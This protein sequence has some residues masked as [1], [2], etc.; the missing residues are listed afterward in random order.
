[1]RQALELAAQ[2]L[3]LTSP[4]PA[5]G[6]LVV[7][8]GRILGRGWHQRA[9]QPHAEIEAFQAARTARRRL[10]D[11]TLYVTLEPC[12]TQGRTPPCTEA[13]LKAG[14]TRV[15]VGAV[16]PNP[17]HA[18]HGLEVL[19][20][21]GVEVVTGV[22]E[23]ECT[24]LNRAFN[25]WIMHGTPWTLLK[26]AMTLDGKIATA[27]GRS[28][29]I[30]GPPARD[31]VMAL[32]RT[33]DAILVGIH[34]VLADDPALTVRWSVPQ[35]ESPDPPIR[36]PRRI[37]L[38]SQARTPLRA[39]VLRDEHAARTIV[40]VT[41]AAPPDRVKALGKMVEVW[42]LPDQGGR[43]DLPSL[44]SKL[45]EAEV[46]HLMVEGGGEVNASFLEA[47]LAHEVAFFYAP[48]VLGGHGSRRV[49]GGQGAR[50][51]AQATRLMEVQW[52]QVG[53][54]LLM[55]ARIQPVQTPRRAPAPGKVDT[56]DDTPTE[57]EKPAGA[58]RS[59]GRGRGRR[60]PPAKA[61]GRKARGTQE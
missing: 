46:T 14:I 36:Q 57:P 38:D 28:K 27:E 35:G 8:G 55:Q 37:I 22:L 48:K 12:S 7:R 21:G 4:N 23:A 6:A 59:R 52:C 29:W 30:T 39:R 26:A 31:R 34:T 54:D 43:V 56:K 47:R 24:D 32:R 45:G 49:I 11:A 2:G 42:T 58:R 25:H 20:A 16:D 13:I 1:M 33:T 3:G 5:V 50:S 18:G 10:Q 17:R 60:R 61:T 44:V 53:E 51:L 15:V 40:V 41:A 19:R 9:G